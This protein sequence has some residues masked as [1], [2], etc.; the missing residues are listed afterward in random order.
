MWSSSSEASIAGMGRKD[1]VRQEGW[2]TQV[3]Q[4]LSSQR[5]AG[6]HPECIRAGRRGQG[7][8]GV[9]SLGSSGARG[10]ECRDIANDGSHESQGPPE[11]PGRGCNSWPVQPQ[12][13]VSVRGTPGAQIRVRPMT[14][15]VWR[16][17]T[18]LSLEA[19]LARWPDRI[20]PVSCLTHVCPGRQR[21]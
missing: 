21:K 20:L 12:D 8:E 16:Q 7:M 10:G 18:D 19:W 11:T 3:M 6:A 5:G 2:G 15:Q 14:C 17:S 9:A 13:S 1:E 4:G